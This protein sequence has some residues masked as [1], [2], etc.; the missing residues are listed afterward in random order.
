MMRSGASGHRGLNILVTRSKGLVRFQTLTVGSIRRRSTFEEEP[1]PDGNED[2]GYNSYD[3]AVGDVVVMILSEIEPKAAVDQNEKDEKRAKDEMDL[4]DDGWL[5]R[6]AVDEVVDDSETEL[7]E[8]C[9]EDD[10]PKN[11]M[12]GVEVS[13]LFSCLSVSETL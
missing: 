5:F 3:D 12:A 7:N 6:P 13:R 9:C 1:E 2:D 11:L 8:D 4:A 10:Q